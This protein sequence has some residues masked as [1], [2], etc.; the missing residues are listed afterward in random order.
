MK[1]HVFIDRDGTLIIEPPIDFQGGFVLEKLEFYPRVFQNLSKIPKNLDYELVMVTNQD[2]LELRV[3]LWRFHQTSRKKMMKA[4]EN[5]GFFSEVC[6]DDS[7][8]HEK[9]TEQ[10]TKNRNASKV[11][12]GNYDLENSFVI[13]D[14][15]NRCGIGEKFRFK[16]Y[17]YFRWNQW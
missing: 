15:K 12:F 3:F 13:G 1:S 7:L 14:R 6:V 8:K 2:G 11:Y 5:E 9:F 4:F 16:I 10:K 17:F